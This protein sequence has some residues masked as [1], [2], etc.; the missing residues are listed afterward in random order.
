MRICRCT[1]LFGPVLTFTVQLYCVS[2]CFIH[3]V[4][5]FD[6][7]FCIFLCVC[8]QE[9]QSKSKVCANV[10]CG[11]GRECAVNEKGEPSCLCIEVSDTLHKYINIILFKNMH[12]HCYDFFLLL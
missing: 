9:A 11:A 5:L 12:G 1:N 7:Y 10:F 2:L 6:V 8:Q 3:I 4:D